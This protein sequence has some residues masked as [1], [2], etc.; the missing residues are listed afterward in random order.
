MS[1][2]FFFPLPFFRPAPP[3]SSP[4]GVTEPLPPAPLP[5]QIPPP[6]SPSSMIVRPTGLA[7]AARIRARFSDSFADGCR[8][9]KS[10]P[11]GARG[12]AREE[13]TAEPGRE[14]ETGVRAGEGREDDERE[15]KA[16]GPAEGA[17]ADAPPAALDQAVPLPAGRFF[18]TPAL[19]SPGILLALLALIS[20]G[21]G[22]E[23][24]ATG[25]GPAEV[26]ACS[27]RAQVEEGLP[28]LR[29]CAE[30]ARCEVLVVEV[31]TPLR[32]GLSA[33]SEGKLFCAN[34]QD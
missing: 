19:A 4:S 30:S 21:N 12:G 3:A 22:F 28:P 20:A 7:S 6:C 13:P 26:A 10:R 27:T 14:M 11:L 25:A 15:G 23:R 34:T 9:G 24:G 29:C 5:F 2:T 32:V 17:E 18:C 16:L 1:T 33:A 31:G 8:E